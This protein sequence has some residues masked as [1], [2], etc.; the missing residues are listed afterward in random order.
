MN[1]HFTYWRFTYSPCIKL[2]KPVHKF[3]SFLDRTFAFFTGGN[4]GTHRTQQNEWFLA[5]DHVT[6]HTSILHIILQFNGITTILTYYSMWHI[7]TSLAHVF[8][9]VCWHSNGSY[10]YLILTTFSSIIWHP[11][12]SMSLQSQ[13]LMRPSPILHQFLTPSPTPHHIALLP[14]QTSL[15]VNAK[16]TLLGGKWWWQL[17]WKIC[18]V[19]QATD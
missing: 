4:N 6:T 17:V 7:I 5:W 8:L 3:M 16:K 12:R 19:W 14:K 1:W 18:A 9:Y 10:C 2:A 15:A 11:E 13:N